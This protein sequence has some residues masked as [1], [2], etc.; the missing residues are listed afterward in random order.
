MLI[1]GRFDFLDLFL[2]P[3]RPEIND[4]KIQETK[5]QET[6]AKILI[7]VLICNLKCKNH[8]RVWVRI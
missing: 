6:K 5:T 7:F 2:A 1:L 8:I 4:F 3:R